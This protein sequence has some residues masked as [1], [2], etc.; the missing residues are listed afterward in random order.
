MAYGTSGGVLLRL[1]L[2]SVET[3]GYFTT[4]NITAAI[5]DADT[6]VDQINDEA[7]AALKTM[8]SN[9]IAADILWNSYGQSQ[10]AGMASRGGVNTEQGGTLDRRQIPSENAKWLLRRGVTFATTGEE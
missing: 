2:P 7:V 1:G 10:L 5:A 9:M 6:I 8:A 4:T 3:T